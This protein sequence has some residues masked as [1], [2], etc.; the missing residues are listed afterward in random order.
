MKFEEIEVGKVYS[1][2]HDVSLYLVVHKGYNYIVVINY[3]TVHYVAV[4]QF[5]MT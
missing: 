2:E 3:S 5:Y 1:A 4:Q